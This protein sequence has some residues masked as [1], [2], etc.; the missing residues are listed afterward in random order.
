[1]KSKVSLL[2]LVLGAFLLLTTISVY[3]LP[4]LSAE[5]AT[6]CVTCH[7]NPNGG[8]M[9]NEFGNFAVAY[10]ELCLQSTKKLVEPNK[11]RSRLSDNVTFGL[12]YRHLYL[13]D[14]ERTFRMQTDFY[15]AIALLRNVSFNLALGQSSVKDSYLMFKF[16]DESYWIKAGRFYP[17]FGLRDPDHNAY[18]RTVPLLGPELNVEGLSVGG[19]LFNGSNITLEICSPNGQTVATLH[20]FRAGSLGKFGFLTG[21]SWRQ[22]EELTDGYRD[23]PIAKSLFGALNY[24]RFTLLG[25]VGAVGKGNEQ[26][27]LYAQMASRL[28]W[29]LHFLSEYNFHD[30]NWAVKSGSNEFWRFSLEFFPIPFVEIRPSATIVGAGPRKNQ[31][32]YF[33]QLHVSY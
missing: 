15:L 22:A 5:H 11:F 26:R 17:A 7:T 33:V 6:P 3:S 16:R 30:P 21:L 4:R 27:T 24:D 19:N 10:N 9:R 13:I 8:G 25:E 31:V 12:D 1:M 29:G 28:L 14:Q 2:A 23:F 20:S 32:D 18:V